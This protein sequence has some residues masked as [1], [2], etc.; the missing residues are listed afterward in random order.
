VKNRIEVTEILG[1]NCS[2]RSRLNI[3]KLLQILEVLSRESRIME[4]YFGLNK[5]A[6][7]AMLLLAL[8]PTG[9]EVVWLLV[10]FGAPQPLAT[11][12]W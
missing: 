2:Q 3:A 4:I 5:S 7:A 1:M 10:S 6:P 11:Q 8:P 12:L 9:S